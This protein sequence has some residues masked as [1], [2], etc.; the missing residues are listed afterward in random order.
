MDYQITV[1]YGGSR[2]RYHTFVVGAEEAGAALR[3]AADRLPP[4][5]AA[6]A[7]LVELRVA[8]DPERRAYVDDDRVGEE[9]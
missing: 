1:R 9:E 6:D 7:D 4:E 5:V 8:A 2:Q 3:A